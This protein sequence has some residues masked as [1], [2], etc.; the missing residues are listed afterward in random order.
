MGGVRPAGLQFHLRSREKDQVV[1]SQDL[2]IAL[3]HRI[4]LR[5]SYRCS[6]GIPPPAA[7]CTITWPPSRTGVRCASSARKCPKAKQTTCSA[8]SAKYNPFKS[9]KD[10]WI[11]QGPPPQFVVLDLSQLRIRPE[12]FNLFG[13]DCWHDYPT[14]PALI[15]LLVSHD[16]K[17]YSSIGRVPVERV[18]GWQY[19]KLPNTPFSK[20]RYLQISIIENHGGE[21]TYINQVMLGFEQREQEASSR[22]QQSSEDSLGRFLPQQQEPP[23]PRP[24]REKV[25]SEHLKLT[26]TERELK[27]VTERV[28]H[29]ES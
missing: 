25:S 26:T 29:L 28:K 22:L 5:R 6:R 1:C 14:N 2:L 20:A 10:L 23:S 27:K 13:L 17:K 16:A 15:E 11:S 7:S 18:P 12:M 21:K 4:N 24:T 19:F 8:P 3:S 9:S